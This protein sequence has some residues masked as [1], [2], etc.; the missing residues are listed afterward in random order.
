[1]TNALLFAEAIVARFVPPRIFIH[2]AFAVKYFQ[3]VFKKNNYV[4]DAPLLFSCRQTRL[5]T[6]VPR[7]SRILNYQ[8]TV[9]IE[10][11]FTK[12]SLHGFIERDAF[13]HFS[14]LIYKISGL[15]NY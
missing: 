4:L 15:T 11:V 3:S 1:M 9:Y 13:S 8:S 5:V 14:K 7:V 2:E 12:I 6:R 10:N